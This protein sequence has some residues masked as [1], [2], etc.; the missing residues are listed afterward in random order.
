MAWI[1]DPSPPGSHGSLDLKAL[2]IN[3]RWG[4][5]GRPHPFPFLSRD[6]FADCEVGGNPP[7]IGWAGGRLP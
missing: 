7:W 4:S 3:W 5:G 2:R 6:L 1:E